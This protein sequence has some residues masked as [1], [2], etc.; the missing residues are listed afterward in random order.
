VAWDRSLPPIQGKDAAFP[1]W[2]KA[3]FMPAAKQIGRLGE[4]MGSLDFW[5]LQPQPGVLV[6]PPAAALPPRQTAAAATLARDR[7]L[8][9]VPE[10]PSVELA[11][12][13]LPPRPIFS[14]HNPRTGE[15]RAA[16]PVLGKTYQVPT[17]APG[18]W[19][20]LVRG[21]PSTE[22]VSRH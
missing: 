18:D 15:G 16:T 6:A 20:L 21:D 2:K 22:D 4:L 19:L 12:D 17:P 14:W 3:L 5:R 13:A 9:Y 8:V 7:A 11:P 10:G 1:A